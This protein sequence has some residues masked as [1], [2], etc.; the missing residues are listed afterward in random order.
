MTT[1]KMQFE[2]SL[3]L[4]PQAIGAYARLSYT[5]WHALAEFIDNSTQ[6]RLNYD[7]LIDPVL[8]SEGTPLVVEI[9][10]DRL[11]KT[12]RIRDNSI[13]MSQSDL[14]AALRIAHPTPDSQGRSRYGMGMKTAACWIGERWQVVTTEWSDT[15]EWMAQIHVPTVAQGGSIPISSRPVHADDHYTEIL[16]SDLNR[17][18]YGRT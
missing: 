6:S 11:N 12:L 7:S 5:M 2:A 9:T 17:N 15:T 13:G 10:H 3:E 1:H 16:I 4:G 18:I 8:A 14:V